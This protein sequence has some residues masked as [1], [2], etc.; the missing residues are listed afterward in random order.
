MDHFL[1]FTVDFTDFHGIS[2][3]LPFTGCMILIVPCTGVVPCLAALR[4]LKK[5]VGNHTRVCEDQVGDDSSMHL[6]DL[7][8]FIPPFTTQAFPN[9][10]EMSII[11]LS[12]FL[13]AVTLHHAQHPLAAKFLTSFASPP[14]EHLLC[15]VLNLHLVAWLVPQP[16]VLKKSLE[17]KSQFILSGL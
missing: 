12:C 7:V 16:L 10:E 4:G 13:D 17:S 1:H 5:V 2:S 3:A 15:L 11:L 8:S 6:P 14:K 9:P